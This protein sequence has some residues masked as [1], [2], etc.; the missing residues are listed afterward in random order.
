[1]GQTQ[2][3]QCVYTLTVLSSIYISSS[4]VIYAG[5]YEAWKACHLIQLRSSFRKETCSQLTGAQGEALTAPQMKV[6]RMFWSVSDR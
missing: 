3:I 5:A 6:L 2:H 1:M 4:I